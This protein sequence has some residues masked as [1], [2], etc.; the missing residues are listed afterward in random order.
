M[1]VEAYEGEWAELDGASLAAFRSLGAALRREA[2]QQHLAALA[3]GSLHLLI[4]AAQT[5]ELS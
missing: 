2:Q 5:H 4:E 3:L 1:L